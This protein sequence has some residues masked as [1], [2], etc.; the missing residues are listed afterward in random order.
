[1][2]AGTQAF[3]LGCNEAAP[4]ALSN[5]L[6]FAGLASL[7]FTVGFAFAYVAGFGYSLEGVF[8]G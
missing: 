1:L 7:P 6:A 5:Q 3:G 8:F 4:L 2:A